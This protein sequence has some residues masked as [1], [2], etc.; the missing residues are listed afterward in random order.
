[1]T[2]DGLLARINVAVVQLAKFDCTVS[3]GYDSRCIFC[4]VEANDTHSDD[5]PWDAARQ[6]TENYSPSKVLYPERNK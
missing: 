2:L 1:M 4:R 5:C 6:I 3:S